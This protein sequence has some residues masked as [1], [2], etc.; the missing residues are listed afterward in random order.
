MRGK[1]QWRT[2][3]R[4]P[5]SEVSEGFVLDPGK[6][7]GIGGFICEAGSETWRTSQYMCKGR[8]GGCSHKKMVDSHKNI[9]SIILDSI[10]NAAHGGET[11]AAGIVTLC[12]RLDWQTGAVWQWTGNQNARNGQTGNRQEL[13]QAGSQ[14]LIPLVGNNSRF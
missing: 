3:I 1:W 14:V 7:H 10:H 9:M 6:N 5:A 11:H 4:V 2:E 13:W 8:M 12:M